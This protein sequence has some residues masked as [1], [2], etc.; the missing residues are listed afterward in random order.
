MAADGY[1]CNDIRSAERVIAGRRRGGGLPENTRRPHPLDD[2][3]PDT[4]SGWWME[5]VLTTFAPPTI[6]PPTI[7]HPANVYQSN[8]APILK[9]RAWRIAFGA[10]HVVVGGGVYVLFSV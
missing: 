6:H 3:L 2:H 9:K 8:C 1:G 7:H 4:R 10:C 5:I